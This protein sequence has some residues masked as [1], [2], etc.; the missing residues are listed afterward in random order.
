MF[1]N[2]KKHINS[3]ETEASEFFELGAKMGLMQDAG[4]VS[5]ITDK[6][7]LINYLL[8]NQAGESI[9]AI[10]TD[11]DRQIELAGT[12]IDFMERRGGYTVDYSDPQSIQEYVDGFDNAIDSKLQDPIA[13]P[14]ISAGLAND[15]ERANLQTYVDNGY[16]ANTPP[17][18][19]P[20]TDLS[21]TSLEESATAIA[22]QAEID[23]KAA[24]NLRNTNARNELFSA[25]SDFGKFLNELLQNLS[26]MLGVWFPDPA[27]QRA[28]AEAL[29]LP[30]NQERLAAG[31]ADVMGEMLEEIPNF[32][33]EANSREEL[34]GKIIEHLKENYTLPRDITIIESDGVTKH[35][36]KAG[37]KIDPSTFPNFDAALE[38]YLDDNGVP[39]D[40]ADYPAFK[41]KI[42]EQVNNHP[43]H[44]KQISNMDD[45]LTALQN[46]KANPFVLELAN[47]PNLR[48][49]LVQA[50]LVAKKLKNLGFDL[51]EIKVDQ[52]LA[53][54]HTAYE[55]DR[56][57]GNQVYQ[58]L[59]DLLS[60]RATINGQE[61]DLMVRSLIRGANTI[62]F[63]DKQL[64]DA[65][66]GDASQVAT[67]AREF[68]KAYPTAAGETVEMSIAV[69]EDPKSGGTEITA[70]DMVRISE[71]VVTVLD[72]T[73]KGL[74]PRQAVAAA[75]FAISTHPDFTD[76]D[77]IL[78][79]TIIRNAWNQQ[80][81]KASRRGSAI[82]AKHI[83]N[84]VFDGYTQIVNYAK[85]EGI[86]LNNVIIEDPE[87]SRLLRGE[88]GS[89]NTVDRIYEENQSEAVTIERN[90]RYKQESANSTRGNGGRRVSEVGDKIENE[91]RG[92]GGALGN[93]GRGV[94][95]VF[96]GSV[97]DGLE[98]SQVGIDGRG[99][100]QDWVDPDAQQ[101]MF[102]IN[103][104]TGFEENRSEVESGRAQ[105]VADLEQ[106]VNA[107]IDAME[108]RGE[109][110]A[111]TSMLQD[112]Q[113]KISASGLVA[114]NEK[115]EIYAIP[116]EGGAPNLEQAQQ[117]IINSYNNLESHLNEHGGDQTIN[118]DTED[119]GR[120]NQDAE[121]AETEK[122]LTEIQA[123]IAVA[124]KASVGATV[125]KVEVRTGERA[126]IGSNPDA[127][128]ARVAE[129]EKENTEAGD[130][131]V[132]EKNDMD[133]LKKSMIESGLMDDKGNAITEGLRGRSVKEVQEAV[134]AYKQVVAG[135]IQDD[136]VNQIENDSL[137]SALAKMVQEVGEALGNRGVKRSGNYNA[138]AGQ[139]AEE[140]RNKSAV[141]S[142]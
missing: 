42:E 115:G 85:D 48:D 34:K 141:V 57:A 76:Q 84:M 62:P 40:K 80:D 118:K 99:Y 90:R 37:Q 82:T 36:I 67:V 81:H 112:Y 114:F 142:Q 139:K 100:A 72:S 93:I 106:K 14:I 124:E 4:D 44:V 69:L 127:V 16:V 132:S 17:P 87:K 107:G 94:L 74:T 119:N 31:F 140:L 12:V 55:K 104:K 26:A 10:T 73:G 3:L 56:S 2:S 86:D 110:F 41:T 128:N 108:S 101:N 130:P 95:N 129:I 11:T 65:L 5:S 6:G 23:A 8:A 52:L 131:N 27:E 117:N 18:P 98:N 79:N 109:Q 21:D 38:K 103:V 47:D 122:I 138:G 63:D 75:E 25:N 77:K 43:K 111:E 133:A 20:N 35:V 120:A 89:G 54:A 29:T 33:I 92:R 70:A 39:K 137:D 126:E 66:H 116:H 51:T 102:G 88:L 61:G 78:A 22:R 134:E 123:R 15:E 7:T 105:R 45:L 97:G 24:E 91:G 50:E 28:V 46:P 9:V 121:F 64:R 68:A 136:D 13:G 96:L 1:Y 125:V 49:A 71:A 19:T 135:A 30:E 83:E 32:A 53:R 113:A 58:S 60:D 59:S